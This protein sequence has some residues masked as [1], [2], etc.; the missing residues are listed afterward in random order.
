MSLPCPQWCHRNSIILFSLLA[1]EAARLY[2][3]HA[4]GQALCACVHQL[5]KSP[6]QDCFTD[7]ETEIHKSNLS[8]V[9]QQVAELP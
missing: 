2:Q 9:P 4:M 1:A 8:G 5:T 6:S 3:A 7:E